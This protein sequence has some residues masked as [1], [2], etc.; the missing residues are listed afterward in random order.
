MQIENS[1]SLGL[2]TPAADTDTL[3]T[4][5]GSIVGIHVHADGP[6]DGNNWNVLFTDTELDLLVEVREVL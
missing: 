1:T 4:G 5:K 6:E 2:G 3:P